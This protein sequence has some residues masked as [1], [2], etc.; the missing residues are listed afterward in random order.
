MIK[1]GLRGM[2]RQQKKKKSQEENKLFYVFAQM[3]CKF[4]WICEY[5][6]AF[7]IPNL[8]SDAV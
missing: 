1:R 5:L 2:R 4:A 8:L 7:C 6:K 3:A